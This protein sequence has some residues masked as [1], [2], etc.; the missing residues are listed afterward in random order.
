MNDFK[1]EH[2]PEIEYLSTDKNSGGTPMP[3]GEI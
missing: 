2:I 1:L 3:R